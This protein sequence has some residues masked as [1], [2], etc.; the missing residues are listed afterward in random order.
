MGKVF[1]RYLLAGFIFQSVVIGGGYGTG[2]ELAEF[3][4]PHGPM[5]GLLGMVVA[6]AV[7]G[8]VLAVTFEFA[9]Q[10]GSYDYRTFFKNLLGRFWVLFE[11]IF[12]LEIIIALSVVGA[13]SG[14]L[15]SEAFGVP[16]IGGTIL[17]LASVIILVFYGSKAIEGFLSV[18]SLLLYAVY[19]VFLTIV[20]T[21][22]G[23]TIAENL[24]QAPVSNGWIIDG[25]RYAG[26]NLAV[27]PAVL[28]VVTHLETRRQAVLSGLFAGVIAIVPAIFFYLGMS[29]YYPEIADA[30][31]PATYMLGAL[32][33]IWLS[34]IFKIMLYGT[35]VETGSGL[36]HAVNERIAINA[37][38][39]GVELS[40]LIRPAVALILLV[41]SVFLATKVGL[42]ELVS[43][44]YG[45]LTYAFILV[46]IIPIMT[47]G[48]YR[49]TRRSA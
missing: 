31:V 35:F 4:L 7:W 26:Y 49:I 2:R 32:G 37:K 3:F 14:E 39:R 33:V 25:V 6:M 42:I 30:P 36:I 27:I 11:I 17:L 40:R 23:G 29:A 45:L 16:K 48:L 22:V 43:K 18:W 21:R 24:A 5:G 47:L 8:V 10:T 20:L 9:R 15:F 28:F 1:Q 44:G 12:I 38:E 19:A 13:A 41:V 34:I 46:Y